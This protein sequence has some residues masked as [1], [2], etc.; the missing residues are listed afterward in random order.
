MNMFVDTDASELGVDMPNYQRLMVVK[1][2]MVAISDPQLQV[3]H[4][5]IGS[6]VNGVIKKP[7]LNDHGSPF[8]YIAR[9]MNNSSSIKHDVYHQANIKRS[10]WKELLATKICDDT[11]TV[12]MR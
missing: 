8:P 6:S 5:C 4:R 10:S 9:E 1:L 7:A 12:V 3:G 2:L 11:K